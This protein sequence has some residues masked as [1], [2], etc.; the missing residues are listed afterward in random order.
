MAYTCKL[1]PNASLFLNDVKDEFDD[2]VQGNT[3][4]CCLI[5]SLSAV[6]WTMGRN[7]IKIMVVRGSYQVY[8]NSKY[9]S[10]SGT[11]CLDDDYK[12]KY[13][14]SR[15]L[16]EIWPG[17]Y[18]K[19]VALHIHN[20]TADC[21]FSNV[22]WDGNPDR[23]LVAL[24]GCTLRKKTSNLPAEVS[25]RCLS[26]KV[27][28]PMVIWNENHCYTVLGQR[29]DGTFLLRDPSGKNPGLDGAI[30][31]GYCSFNNHFT[32]DCSSDYQLG[33]Y[34]SYSRN[35]GDGLFAVSGDVLKKFTNLSYVGKV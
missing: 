1:Y 10:V 31:S 27:K 29:A 26:G 28:Y 15:I 11:L 3:D 30:I 14:H 21:D 35:L 6:D 23:Y 18:E 16:S 13:A 12:F 17:L 2:P 5:A 20:S 24:T 22:S 34:G 7:K 9:L 33:S 25:S 4:N 19:A 8:L 32:W